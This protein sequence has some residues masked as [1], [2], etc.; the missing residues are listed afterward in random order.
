MNDRIR[1][2]WISVRNGMIEMAGELSFES[3]EPAGQ[4]GRILA[5]DDRNDI[6]A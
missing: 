4:T 5:F 2:N 3:M 6:F 1:V